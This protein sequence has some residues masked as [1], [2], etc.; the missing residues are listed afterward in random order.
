MALGMTP[1]VK[2]SKTTLV[3]T[4]FMN[5]LQSLFFAEPQMHFGSSRD[6]TV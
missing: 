4:V 6:R 3:R 2:N 5:P 1:I